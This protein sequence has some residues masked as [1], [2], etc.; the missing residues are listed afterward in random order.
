VAEVVEEALGD[1]GVPDGLTRPDGRRGPGG[2]VEGRAH[3]RELPGGGRSAG[4]RWLATT[5]S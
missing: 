1:L 2:A 4:S 5:A 3:R